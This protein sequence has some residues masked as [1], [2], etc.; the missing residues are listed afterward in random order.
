MSKFL[1]NLL[2]QI[3]KA[4]VYSKIK[5]YSEK[6]FSVAFGPAMAHSFFLLSNWPLPLSPLGLGLSAGPSR[7]LGLADLAPVAPC[8]IAASHT[9]RHLQPRRL[10]TLHAR[11]TSGPHLSSLTSGSA[12]LSLDATASHRSPHRPARHLGCRPSRY[13]SRHHSPPP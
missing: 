13:S 8:R 6:N 12:E 9:G 1:L 4:L 3:S 7:P 5:F 2:V 11:L 10:C